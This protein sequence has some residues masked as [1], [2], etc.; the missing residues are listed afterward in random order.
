[1]KRSLTISGS[2]IL[3]SVAV[4]CAMGALVSAFSL[5]VDV[6]GLLPIW[7][8]AILSLTIAVAFFKGKGIL[9]MVLPALALLWLKLPEVLSG[10]KGTVYLISSEYNKWLHVPVLFSGQIITPNELR[11]FFAAAGIVLAFVLSVSICL[12][13]SAL[14]TIFYTVPLLL[15]TVVITESTPQIAYFIGLF[16]VYL[17]MIVSSSLNPDDY[18]KRGN[19]IYIAMALALVILSGAYLAARPDNYKRSSLF[20]EIDSRVRYTIDR[21]G[22]GLH[23]AGVGWLATGTEGWSYNTER[24]E[25]ANAG[26]HVIRDISLL[27]V[28]SDKA[29]V[30]YLKGFSVINFNGREWRVSSKSRNHRD[31]YMSVYKP[32]LIAAYYSLIQEAFDSIG[33]MLVNRTGDSSDMIY[34][35]YYSFFPHESDYLASH[36]TAHIESEGTSYTI[37]FVQASKGV[38]DMYEVLL[39]TDSDSNAAGIDAELITRQDLSH[40]EATQLSSYRQIEESTAR[41]LRRI[42]IEAGIDPEAGREEIADMVAGFISSSARYTLTPYVTPEGEDFALYFLQTSKRGYCIHFATAATLMLRALDI[43]ARFTCGFTVEITPAQVGKPVT[44]TDRQAHAWVEV[45]YDGI[46]WLPLEVTPS[47][48]GT[49]LFYRI[50]GASERDAQTTATR[51]IENNTDPYDDSYMDNTIDADRQNRQSPT[52]EPGTGADAGAQQHTED[53]KSKR[54][55]FRMLQIV[56]A[57]VLALNLNR[58]ILRTWRKK[59]FDRSDTNAAVLRIWRYVSRL[60]R[61]ERPPKELEELAMK[62]RFSQHLITQE[63]RWMMLNKA[64]K[65]AEDLYHRQNRLKRVWLKYVRGV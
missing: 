39:E 6:I 5:D 53:A 31:E 1:M 37:D 38:L 27:E 59:R 34:Y 44:V 36:S 32:T 30:F 8:I 56:S 64:S 41:E 4:C 55:G 2:F 10:A 52:P 46:G 21:V 58:I 65:F 19:N 18:G 25:I 24:I 7:L 54:S 49:N 14:L 29:G 57:C 63:E 35:P 60:S 3:I 15:L 51:T 12:Q 40:Y 20:S 22:L 28:T 43:P 47:N 17:T 26:Y 50:A 13:K 48:R 33:Q 62:A 42:A 16:A 61:S 9:V 11:L 45:Y 23:K